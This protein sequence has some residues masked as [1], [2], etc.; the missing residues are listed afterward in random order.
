MIANVNG[1]SQGG[2]NPGVFCQMSFQLNIHF[3]HNPGMRRGYART[4]SAR[5]VQ[6]VLCQCEPEQGDG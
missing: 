2:S 5:Q 1:F 4:A 3:A 6:T